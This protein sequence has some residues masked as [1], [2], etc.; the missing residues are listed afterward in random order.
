M[1]AL[2]RVGLVFLFLLVVLWRK[3]GVGKAI[4]LCAFVLGLL[5]LIPPV[6][7]RRMFGHLS[8]EH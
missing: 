3:V 2:I 7:Y 4:F 6:E 8:D 1:S 5:F